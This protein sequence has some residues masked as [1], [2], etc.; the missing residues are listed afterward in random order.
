MAYFFYFVLI[1][2]FTLLVFIGMGN[3]LI[4]TYIMILFITKKNYHDRKD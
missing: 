1:F 2:A 3:P 4:Y